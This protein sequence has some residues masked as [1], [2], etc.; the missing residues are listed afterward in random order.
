[1]RGVN[2]TQGRRLP[3]HH[4][5]AT[6]AADDHPLP[7]R[8]SSPQS[9]YVRRWGRESH[10]HFLSPRLSSCRIARF[11]GARS[12]SANTAATCCVRLYFFK[13]TTRSTRPTPLRGRRAARFS[14]LRGKLDLATRSLGLLSERTDNYLILSILRKSDSMRKR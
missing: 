6:V 4:R 12:R 10:S 3:L 13:E 11:R 14:S 8:L 5:A 1:M 7:L 9:S 2:E